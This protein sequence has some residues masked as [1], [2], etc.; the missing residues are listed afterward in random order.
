MCA[1]YVR[2]L[3][4]DPCVFIGLGGSGARVISYLKMYINTL[5]KDPDEPARQVLQFLV[6][7][8]DDFD[9]LPDVA[10]LFLDKENE[11][12]F[13]G[14]VAP[15]DYVITQ[16]RSN[17]S[18]WQDMKQ[19]LGDPP[20]DELFRMLPEG[21]VYRG[22]ERL[23]VLSR[24]LFYHHR[25]AVEQALR[26]KYT[27]A[28]AARLQITQEG[29]LPGHPQLRTFIISGTCG[30][31]GSGIFFDV[32]HAV[33]RIR[34]G[35]TS[36]ESPV[37]AVLLMPDFYVALHQGSAPGLVPY[38]QANGYAFFQ[39]LSY[40]LAHPTKLNEY[41][42]DAVTQRRSS[43][44]GHGVPEG[45]SLLQWVY[46]FDH[47][48]PDLGAQDLSRPEDYYAFV[49][50][51]FFHHLLG[52]SA[53]Q[54]EEGGQVG[55]N[56]V[57][58]RVVNFRSRSNEKDRWGAPR[59]FVG[60]GY[61][62]LMYPYLAAGEYFVFKL[63]KIFLDNYLLAA[64]DSNRVKE[65]VDR[66][67]G[68]TDYLIQGFRQGLE[69][70]SSP[71]LE[72]LVT[73]PEAF[74]EG[75]KVDERRASPE[76]LAGIA[77]NVKN[78]LVSLRNELECTWARERESI[79]ARFRK[80][81]E[82]E[83]WSASGRLGFRTTEEVLKTL[84]TRLEKKAERLVVSG[85]Q[86][87]SAAWQTLEDLSATAE[88]SPAAK[89]LVRK[90]FGQEEERVKNLESFL[91]KVR[92]A[93]EEGFRG[94]VDELCGRMLK[95][96]TGDPG[97]RNPQIPV[98]DERTGRRIG[99]QL[100][101]SVLDKLQDTTLR[102][103]LY[104]LNRASQECITVENWRQKFEAVRAVSV[105]CQY[106]PAPPTIENLEQD[107]AIKQNIEQALQ[108]VAL[109][110]LWER[111]LAELRSVDWATQIEKLDPRHVERALE[112][113]IRRNMPII[114][115]DVI[116]LLANLSK[117]KRA[118]VLERFKRG[119]NVALPISA[120]VDPGESAHETIVFSLSPNGDRDR[121][122]V[123]EIEANN[124]VTGFSHG[125]ISLV[126]ETYLVGL[127]DLD[128]LRV[129]APVYHARN[130]KI[131]FPHIDINFQESGVPT[132][133]HFLEERLRM[134]AFARAIDRML[135]EQPGGK[136]PQD[137]LV[138]LGIAVVAGPLASFSFFRSVE[139]PTGT[140]LK[141]ES[142][143]QAVLFTREG[144]YWK[145]WRVVQLGSPKDMPACLDQYVQRQ[146]IYENHSA[147]LE[148]CLKNHT[149]R[150]L[151][152]SPLGNYL[153]A[154]KKEKEKLEAALRARG[155]DRALERK[156]TLVH[157][158]CSVVEQ[159]LAEWKPQPEAEIESI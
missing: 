55:Q 25:E 144:E 75:Q 52:I 47:R 27:A 110:Q 153:V 143:L 134:F 150:C 20:P 30:G 57:L 50:R 129:L 128:S 88:G 86:K 105:T 31:T 120:H 21:R 23:R 101:V 111:V 107:E 125:H 117:R 72:G 73:K 85:R 69:N 77:S 59:V 135:R 159:T 74:Y 35:D 18:A 63:A 90:M 83:I 82:D 133:N 53:V 112:V 154:A 108:G 100:I 8:A 118:E 40:F 7:D 6:I 102:A 145:E 148:Q 156:F 149:S 127:S 46:L 2:N 26:K 84:D 58:Q 89:V 33:H 44:P 51:A 43:E 137:L 54:T 13:I 38:Y 62:E 66:L 97:D 109:D 11:F 113:A 136:K 94:I 99:E 76:Q 16:Q 5:F 37:E 19:W 61:S 79:E 122:V 24:I 141:S 14:G 29:R 65:N 22:A 114:A 71:I 78:Q 42:A 157:T 60:I 56:I 67:E 70:Q 138:E 119:S 124:W 28:G 4:T 131:N 10:R 45:K 49:A 9:S 32:L 142:Q 34:S 91:G 15:R 39:E 1:M 106:L 81:I 126:R 104:A 93:A 121:E 158:L 36:V 3:G 68:E 41:T 98:I 103:L 139:I 96:L 146:E 140:T 151:L 48:I 155:R 95:C 17:S 123:G 115:Q 152:L 132:V 64:A 80:L 130:R 116:K 147:I 12:F 92:S 87:Q